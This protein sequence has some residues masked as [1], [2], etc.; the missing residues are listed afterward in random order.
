MVF[1]NKNFLLLLTFFA[2]GIPSLV[3]AQ[4]DNLGNLNNTLNDS[5]T[6]HHSAKK[7]LKTI[8]IRPSKN[9]MYTNECVSEYAASELGFEYVILTGDCEKSLGRHKG[10]ELEFHN[11]FT[12]LGFFF[13]KGPFWKSKINKRYK[14]CRERMGDVID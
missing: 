3:F 11:F 6:S 10:F 4:E 9:N 1:T 2:L 12:K 5:R 14:F 7:K 13:T 8:L